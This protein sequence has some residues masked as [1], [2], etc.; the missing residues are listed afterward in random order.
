[1]GLFS[2]KQPELAAPTYV[3]MRISPEQMPS[4]VDAQIRQMGA[5]FLQPDKF[6]KWALDT[7]LMGNDKKVGIL[8]QDA[9]PSE[10]AGKNLISQILIPPPLMDALI[11][12]GDP[13]GLLM[14][15]THWE[16]T[17]LKVLTFEDGAD[18]AGLLAFLMDEK[19]IQE[20]D[21]PA[22]LVPDYTGKH[23][24]PGEVVNLYVLLHP[25][26]YNGLDYIVFGL[27][28]PLAQPGLDGV[29]K[30]LHE[31]STLF[32]QGKAIPGLVKIKL[33]GEFLKSHFYLP[34]EVVEA[35]GWWA[36]ET[37]DVP[38]SLP[39]KNG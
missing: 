23:G 19:G 33:S 31:A 1:M 29:S 17:A 8:P 34:R 15:F 11:G 24:A 37:P 16:R 26:P 21:F 30:A 35:T 7:M 6:S 12:K 4:E 36:D 32:N 22:L 2:K 14:K 28:P 20:R 10:Y 5:L 3:D 9:D 18:K 27:F 25:E 38:S 39:H 13:E